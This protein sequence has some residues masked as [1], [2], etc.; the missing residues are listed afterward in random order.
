MEK[1][2]VFLSQQMICMLPALALKV[3]AY[4]LNW[5]KFD[6]IKYY[7]NQMTK[8]MHITEKELELAIQTLEDNK[9]IDI[10]KNDGIFVFQINKETV[11]KYFNVEMKT[12]HDHEGIKMAT[13]VKWNVEGDKAPQIE[14]MSLEQM[15]KMMQ[16]LQIQI[17]E[18]EQTQKLIKSACEPSDGLPW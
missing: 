14:D 7:P 8:F 10:S 16:M 13:E 4:L 5:Q 15:K 17:S 18:K 11:K 6:V 9:L 12:I 1:E 3:M 2:K